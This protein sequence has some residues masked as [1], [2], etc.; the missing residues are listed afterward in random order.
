VEVVR[1]V[2]VSVDAGVKAAAPPEPRGIVSSA[3]RVVE[4]MG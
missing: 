2:D 1:K 3:R 4:V